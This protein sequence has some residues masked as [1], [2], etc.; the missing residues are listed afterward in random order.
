MIS[1]LFE[2]KLQSMLYFGPLIVGFFRSFWY[3]DVVL[4]CRT[5][6]GSMKIFVCTLGIARHDCSEA[7]VAI[8]EQDLVDLI[9]RRHVNGWSVVLLRLW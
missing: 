7:N 3:R 5:N 9:C 1:G 8:N 2:V 4:A 6:G